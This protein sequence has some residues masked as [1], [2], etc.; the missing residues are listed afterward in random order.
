MKAAIV[1][2]HHLCCDLRFSK[3]ESTV[4]KAHTATV[5]SVDFSSDGLNLLT[6]SDDKTI[7]VWAVHRQKFQFSLTQHM[8]W[9]RSAK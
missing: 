4:F 1:R 7:K 8:N 6:C 2:T 5:R 9:V 3:G